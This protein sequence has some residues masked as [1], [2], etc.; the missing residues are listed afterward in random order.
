MVCRGSYFGTANRKLGAVRWLDI[1][2]DIGTEYAA[3][4]RELETDL[5]VA[6]AR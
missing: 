3:Q 6:A 4:T 2:G 5:M 1:A